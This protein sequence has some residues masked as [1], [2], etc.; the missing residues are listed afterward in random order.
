MKKINLILECILLVAVAIL[1]VLHFT[2]KPSSVKVVD[3]NGE[4]VET[5]AAADGAIV[6]VRIDSLMQNYQQ[7]KD[8]SNEL[9]DKSQKLDAELNNKLK[10]FQSNVTDFQ[11]K[12][13]K[14]LETRAKL[15]E[16]EQQLQ[17]D[18]QNL[19]Q[20]RDS[21]AMQLS[22]E[23]QVMNRK[24]LQAIMDYLVEFNK[25]KGYQYIL[26][27]SFGGNVLYS[28]QSLD[29]TDAVISGI[30]AGYKK[31]AAEKPEK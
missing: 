26:G 13:Q 3:S 5:Q 4:V 31:P 28:A 20:L 30:N 21:Y 29:I 11:N 2:Q 22:E 9:K 14:G 17:A 25:D 19:A 27:S 12:A 23:E 7:Y 6:Y 15:A 10:K 8:L 1:F 24:C 16:M 18:Q